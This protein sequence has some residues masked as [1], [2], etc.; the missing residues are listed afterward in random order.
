[1]TVGYHAILEEDRR[2]HREY[3]EYWEDLERKNPLM[4]YIVVSPRWTQ[5]W[6]RGGGSLCDPET[7]SYPRLFTAVPSRLMNEHG[8]HVQMESIVREFLN[9]KHPGMANIVEMRLSDGRTVIVDPLKALA[10]LNNSKEI[11]MIAD[12]VIADLV[13]K[14]RAVHGLAVQDV[15]R[16]IWR[17]TP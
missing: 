1:M 11:L 2:A 4:E 16:D 17:R 7:L 5:L 10:G 14:G 13:N 12:D 6:T 15:M 9:R 3:R 8:A